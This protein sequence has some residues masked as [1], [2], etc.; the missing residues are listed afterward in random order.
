MEVMDNVYLPLQTMEMQ[1]W[2]L[3][4]FN[5]PADVP[6]HKNQKSLLPPEK[7]ERLLSDTTPKE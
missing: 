3:H 1:I 7:R 2:L 6:F 4:I 5:L